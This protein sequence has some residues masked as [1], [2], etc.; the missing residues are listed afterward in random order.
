M[1]MIIH[2]PFGGR[3]NRA[4]G[5][6]LRKKF[7]AGFNFELQAAATD[8]GILL[9]LGPQH[10]F[11]LES[12][13]DF[14]S[15]KSVEDTLEQAVLDAPVF[16]VRWRWNATRALA[17]LRQS[18]GKRVPPAIQ[19]IR[20]DDLLASVFPDQAACQENVTRP[21]K[22]PDHPL[23][24]ETMRDCLHEAMNLEGLR[25]LLERIEKREVKL[26]AK[27][28]PTP[29]PL[30]HEI[31]NSNPYTYLDDAPLE[32]R[33]ARA[34]SIRRSLSEEDLRAFGAL[35]EEAIAAVEQEIW[36]D[37]RSADELADTVRELFFLPESTLPM[38]W[39][40][41]MTV[42]VQSGRVVRVGNHFVSMDRREIA[43]KALKGD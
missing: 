20:S 25:S 11:P 7:C 9:S 32:E 35:D 2:A 14:L 31:L 15:S 28:T 8:D 36:P 29:S 13:F 18:G 16:G 26:I 10:S 39:K 6:A 4:F 3:L 5:L 37:V 21:I 38:E 27:D 33:R 24:T 42:L 22:I 12:V 17:L 19:R 41:W 43:E 40:E 1:Q 23:I 34:V 30:S